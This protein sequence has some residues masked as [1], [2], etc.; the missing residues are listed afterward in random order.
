MSSSELAISMVVV[1]AEE[2][3]RV[4]EV[5]STWPLLLRSVDGLEAPEELQVVVVIFVEDG[6]RRWWWW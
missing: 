3:G 4:E 2:G 5:D 1:D 6:L